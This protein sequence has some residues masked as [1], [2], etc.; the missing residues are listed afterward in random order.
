[1]NWQIF[2]ERV[3]DIIKGSVAIAKMF[4]KS[5]AEKKQ[6]VFHRVIDAVPEGVVIAESVSGKDVFNDE[7]IKALLD[8]AVEA[9][10]AAQKARAA[11]QAG[12]LTKAPVA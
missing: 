2:V 4:K 7:N 8:A 11:L 12:L 6:D 1:M 9:E 3:P 10:Y 5:G